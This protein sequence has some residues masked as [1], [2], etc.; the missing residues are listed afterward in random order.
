MNIL[1]PLGDVDQGRIY[2]W[3]FKEARDF[4]ELREAKHKLYWDACI[5]LHNAAT[6]R[7]EAN[8]AARLKVVTEI[9]K[10]NK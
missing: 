8:E 7:H 1:N 9:E 10:L 3:A 5:K 2:G 4:F 6:V